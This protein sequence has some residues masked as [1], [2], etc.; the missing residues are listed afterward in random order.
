MTAIVGSTRQHHTAIADPVER[1]VE[2]GKKLNGLPNVAKD[3]RELRQ[4]TVLELR[5]AGWSYGQI[6]E[7]L[8]L[9]RHRVQQIAEGRTGK[10]KRPAAGDASK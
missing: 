10:S 1:A 9:H 4:E 5:T 2:I 6:G 3:L 8:G 7:A